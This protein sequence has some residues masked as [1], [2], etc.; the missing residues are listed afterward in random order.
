MVSEAGRPG[1]QAVAAAQA[2]GLQARQVGQVLPAVRQLLILCQDQLD[3]IRQAAQRRRQLREVCV[4][5]LEAG[6]VQAL[7]VGKALGQPQLAAQLQA[8]QVGH[9]PELLR[10]R[11]EAGILEAQ[12]GE[13]RVLHD[14]RQ[15]RL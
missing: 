2:E 14:G 12:P 7:Q 1:V 10:Q 11:L 8:A 9:A 13:L 4:G 3:E 15:L 5:D 6:E